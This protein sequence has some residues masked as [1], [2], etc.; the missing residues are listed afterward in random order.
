[1]ALVS[2]ES[3]SPNLSSVTQKE[4]VAHLASCDRL[5][6]SK[7]NEAGRTI[8]GPLLREVLID[9]G[10]DRD[11]RG[12]SVVGALI[13]DVLDLSYCTMPVPLRLRGAV[14]NDVLKLVGATITGQFELTGSELN[15]RNDHG[16]ALAADLMRVDGDTLLAQLHVTGG[17]VRLMDA[18]ITGALV[19]TGAELNSEDDDGDALVADRICVDGDAFMDLK[20]AGGAVRLV[21]ATI[22]GALV[23]TGAEL[24]GRNDHGNALAADR[25]RVDGSAFLKELKVTGGAVRLTNATIK[26]HLDLTGAKLNGK[27]DYD[28]A[29]VADRVCVNGDALLSRIEVPQGAVR[30]MGATITGQLKLLKAELNGKND[31]NNALPPTGYA[32]TAASF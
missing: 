28:D 3:L 32:S 23:L 10:A 22:T 14:F 9:K 18:T 13:S 27:D 26:G 2:D 11:P 12:L 20:V 15:G 8:A 24:H 16:N 31:H 6:L 30:L 5:D 21:G 19:L 7:R 29:L 4:L 17:A 25:M 1:M